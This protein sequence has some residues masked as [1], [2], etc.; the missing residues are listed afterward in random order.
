M[1]TATRPEAPDVGATYGDEFCHLTTIDGDVPICGHP[2]RR[3][4]PSRAQGVIVDAIEARGTCPACGRP[5]C[6]ACLQIAE[7]SDAGAWEGAGPPP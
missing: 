4:C 2:A 3:N 7:V 5:R 6:P 1:T